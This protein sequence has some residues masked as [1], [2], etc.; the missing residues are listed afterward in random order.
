MENVDVVRQ[1][2]YIKAFLV[3]ETHEAQDDLASIGN[4]AELKHRFSVKQL[5]RPMGTLVVF[6]VRGAFADDVIGGQH[7]SLKMNHHA[8]KRAR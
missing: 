7:Q 5:Q 3:K 8:P 6:A 4:H 2:G 1:R